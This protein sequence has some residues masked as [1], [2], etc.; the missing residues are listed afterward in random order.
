MPA[1]MLAL[2]LVLAATGAGA[3]IAAVESAYKSTLT[4][5]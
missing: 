4:I 5:D 1:Y 2:S 3:A